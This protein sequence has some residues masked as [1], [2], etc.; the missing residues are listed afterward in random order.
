MPVR[1]WGRR[2]V[3][4]EETGRLYRRATMIFRVSTAVGEFRATAWSWAEDWLEMAEDWYVSPPAEVVEAVSTAVSDWLSRRGV[5]VTF[6]L[7]F[8]YHGGPRRNW[9]T[10]YSYFRV[11]KP[12]GSMPEYTEV[13][14]VELE[15]VRGGGRGLH[16]PSID[17]A[18]VSISLGEVESRLRD[19]V[20]E[21]VS[22]VRETLVSEHIE[23][24]VSWSP[25]LAGTIGGRGEIPRETVDVTLTLRE[26]EGTVHEK[27]ATYWYH[28]GRG[29]TRG[30]LTAVA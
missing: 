11:T 28:P 4:D 21:F 26:V 25:A 6:A 22:E 17:V 10:T 15:D 23:S 27:L 14:S 8:P 1:P 13:Y 18:P 9:V 3:V 5:S 30:E 20:D 12:L 7:E 19:A 24:I 16:Y 29:E 2:Y